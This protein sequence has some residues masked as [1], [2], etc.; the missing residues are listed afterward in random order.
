[1]PRLID[2]LYNEPIYISVG[3]R[4]FRI[5]KDLFSSPGDSPNYF[6]L[7]FGF[8]FSS[9][10]EIFP[11]LEREGLLRP[12]SILPPAIPNR[13]AEIFEELLAL[14]RGYEVTIRDETHRRM[15]L[16]DAR[17]FHFRGLEQRLVPHRIGY[18]FLRR[19]H[20]IFMMLEDV[21][22]SKLEVQMDEIE[23][24]RGGRGFMGFAQ[25]ARPFCD[26]L[27]SE[28]VVEIGEELMTLQFEG[29]HGPRAEFDSA[30]LIR[31][32][33]NK[34][35]Q[36]GLLEGEG[37]VDSATVGTTETRRGVETVSVDLNDAHVTLDGKPWKW[38]EASLT[39]ADQPQPHPPADYH[40]ARATYHSS[41]AGKDLIS[42]TS[43]DGPSGEG[44]PKKRQRT[45]VDRQIVDSTASDGAGVSAGAEVQD[46]P[47]RWAVQ[48][49][50]WRIRVQ[51]PHGSP[52]GV[53]VVLVGVKIVA[54]S[55]EWGR[56]EAMEF[57]GG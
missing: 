9:P 16:R 3:G 7:G 22:L 43:S 20:E 47:S 4:E 15:L 10:K 36:V 29:S 14:L 11:G 23:K 13:S 17:Y 51:R 18:N 41:S 46:A 8:L 2:Q 44:P 24:P 45:E 37:T 42:G 21:K 33:L 56:N 48:R 28:L 12:P 40:S 57:L 52:H 27:H 55:G 35:A 38:T 30:T 53:E 6:T 1:V 5:P 26:D 39:T 54:T 32:L 50:Q 34:V 19:R 25:Y 31:R 49:G